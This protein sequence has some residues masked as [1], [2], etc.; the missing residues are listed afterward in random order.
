MG[1]RVRIGLSLVVLCAVAGCGGGATTSSPAP[2]AVE[3]VSPAP[4]P[5]RVE[6]KVDTRIWVVFW[7]GVQVMTIFPQAGPIK[8]EEPKTASAP[9]GG[10]SR[11][12]SV[13]SSYVE[14]EE[15]FGPVIAAATDLED[16]LRRLA[17]VPLT[18][19]VEEVN[20][21]YR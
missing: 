19:I 13:I 15:E 3:E 21:V 10:T 16:L 9:Y 6:K 7:D 18:E 20:P 11:H 12:F 2:A 1:R 8:S 14:K 4:A 5:A 17:E